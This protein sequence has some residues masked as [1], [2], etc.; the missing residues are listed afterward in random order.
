MLIQLINKEDLNAIE[1]CGSVSLPIYYTLSDLKFLKCFD[2]D[3]IKMKELDNLKTLAKKGFDKL[4]HDD[5]LQKYEKKKLKLKALKI[6]R[7]L[8]RL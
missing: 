2:K 8:L 1:E 6:E 7:S 3:D 4:M 5:E